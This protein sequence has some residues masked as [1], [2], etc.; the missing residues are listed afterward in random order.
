MLGSRLNVQLHRD[1]FNTPWGFRLQ[2]GRDVNEPHTVRRVFSNSPAEGQLQ[3]GDVILSINSRDSSYLS[4]KEFQDILK[5]GGEV[6]Q[7]VINRP[8]PGTSTLPL[9]PPS[10]TDK[11]RAPS[12]QS[13]PSY[14]TAARPI[15]IQMA[16]PN[17]YTSYNGP[18]QQLQHK[19]PHQPLH[20]YASPGPQYQH[21][22]ERQ[23]SSYSQPPT[24][25]TPT[26]PVPPWAAQQFAPKKVTK[27]SKLGG[28]GFDFGT[29]YATL[30]RGASAAHYGGRPQILSQ[31][32]YDGPEEVEPAR[33]ATG[34]IPKVCRI[35][36]LGGGGYDFGSAFGS[37]TLPRHGVGRRLSQPVKMPSSAGFGYLPSKMQQNRY[38]GGRPEYGSDY[39]YKG[40]GQS[41]SQRIHTSLDVTLSPRAAEV[42]ESSPYNSYDQYYQKP[43]QVYTPTAL[44]LEQ[45]RLQEQQENGDA[46]AP[47]WQR[48]KQFQQGSSQRSEVR[49]PSSQPGQRISKP[50]PAATNYSNFGTDY[51]RSSGQQSTTPWRPESQSKPTPVPVHISSVATYIPVTVQY[52]SKPAPP[53]TVPKPSPPAPSAP[54]QTPPAWQRQEDEE[55]RTPAWRNT[56][57]TTGVKPWE[58]ETGYAIEQ[59]PVRQSKQPPAVAPKPQYSPVQV[60]QQHF[61]DEI[62]ASDF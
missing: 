56:L 34:P 51:R 24:T 58:R 3:R 59:Q 57:K 46:I 62:G 27:L 26:T 42:S 52:T 14:S 25:P 1:S 5:S 16:E 43:Q 6:I 29:V 7:L 17:F 13:H 44:L 21:G 39:G 4:Y 47:V 20:V 54:A 22:F 36:D 15:T 55:T 38:G 48:R 41:P 19:P 33:L 12:Q 50:S 30:P 53:P 40:Y 37:A 10:V 61:Y 8:A 32:S 23:R 2:G 11:H 28:G 49:I 31:S 35:R 60:Q 45:Q 18:S 9:S